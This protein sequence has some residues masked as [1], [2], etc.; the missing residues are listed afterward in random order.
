[1]NITPILY[2]RTLEH[3]IGFDSVRRLISENCKSSLGVALVENMQFSTDFELVTSLLRQTDEMMKIALSD[4]PLQLNDI[5][6]ATQWLKNASVEGAFI[7]IRELSQLR[8]SLAT[9]AAIV[10]FFQHNTNEQGES[11]FPYLA[12]LAEKLDAAPEVVRTINK[13]LDING[14]VKDNASPELKDIRSQLSTIGTRIS[15]AMRRVVSNGIRDGYLEADVTPTMRDGR[16]VLPV[17]PMNKRRISGIV[18]DES[19]SGKTYFIEPAEVVELNNRQREL[20]IE[21]RREIVRILIA[22]ADVIRPYIPTLICTYDTLG[23]FDFINAKAK[24]AIQTNA[25]LPHLSQHTEIEWYSARHPIL[26]LSLERHNRAIVP[27]EIKLQP[28]KRI[29]VISGPNAGGKSVTLKTVGI[30]QYMLQCGVLPTVYENS[31]MGIFSGIFADIGDDQSLEDDLSTYSSHLS[32]MKYILAHG[33]KSSLILIDEFGTGTEPQIGGAIAQALLVQ[34]NN[35]GMWGVITT[36][37]QNLKTLADETKGLVNGSM[38]YD[39]Q[40]MQPLFK[41]SIGHPGSSF[42]VEIA[43]KIGLPDDIINAAKEIVGSDYINL[44]K[45]LLDITRDKRYWENKRQQVRQREKHL[46]Q[47]IE[48]Y[49]NDAETLRANRRAIIADARQQAEQIIAGSN[50]SIERTIHDIRKAQAEKEATVEARRRLAEERKAYADASHEDSAADHPL[51]KRAPKAKKKKEVKP[52][53]ETPQAIAVGENV[54][55][56]NAGQPGTVLEVNGKK[57][58]VA[59]GAM[60][61]TVPVTRLSHTMRKASQA[62]K[63]ASFISTSTSD[64]MRDRQLNFNPDIDVRGMRADEATQAVTY[65]LDDALQ[66]NIPRVRI[67]HG[68][69]T[70]ALRVSLRKYLDTVPGVRSYRDEDVRFGG[71]GI[72]VVEL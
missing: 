30:V 47:V 32:N 12:L 36:H 1:M 16:L 42:A 69:G 28:D 49:E 41:L 67:L 72:T 62:P 31:R 18:H 34:F 27:L 60:K 26:Q 21:E 24:F 23:H 61:I 2:P 58:L 8:A 52:T 4:T 40:L 19:A 39:R 45:Y 50:A 56:D 6:D 48:R 10:S 38:L 43:R 63:A 3:K 15:T 9:V 68:T 64:S 59:F 13:V 65:F 7:D 11:A 70:G 44:D 22:V 35:K 20:E 33:S 5:V 51:L 29:L 66:F 25:S 46:E 17:A 54:L 14:E 57:A 71:A 55:L 53:V 37:Y